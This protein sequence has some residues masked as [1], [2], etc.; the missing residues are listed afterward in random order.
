V[1]ITLETPSGLER[2]FVLPVHKLST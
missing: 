2:V 1:R